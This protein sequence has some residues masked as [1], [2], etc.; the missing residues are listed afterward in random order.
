MS[1]AVEQITKEPS[2]SPKAPKV[3]DPKKVAAGKKLAEKHRRNQEAYDREMKREAE[4]EAKKLEEEEASESPEEAS[5][6]TWIPE[7]SFSTVISIIGVGIAAVD[8]YMRYKNSKGEHF[9]WQ[10]VTTVV[11][12][13]PAPAPAS[14]IPVPT[15]TQSNEVPK[16]GMS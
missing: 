4:A 10:P 12:R 14:K 13:E 15:P 2:P 16:I 8:L 6:Q 5:S 1:D 9:D 3:K 7:L 11:S